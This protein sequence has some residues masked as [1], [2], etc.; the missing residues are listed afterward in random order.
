[1]AFFKKAA[2]SALA[3]SFL[4][5]TPVFAA[6]WTIDPAHSII[7]FSG[8]QTGNTFT[9][10]FGKFD[11]TVSL[12]PAHPED[13][14]ATITINIAS[15][16]T[17]DRQRDSAM[18]RSDWFNV[19]SFPTATFEAR[20]FRAKGGNAYEAVGTLTI[21][22]VS[23]PETL[24]F[25]LDINGPTAH[26]KGHLDLIRSAFGIGQGPWATGQWVALQ[27]GVTIDITASQTSG[28]P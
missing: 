22:G 8:T 10:H 11:G 2:F 17:A 18:P 9:G 1:M 4:A 15:A 12:D 19:A 24:P 7:G 21:R 16:T 23:R 3:M 20:S 26:A 14:H 27:V 5:A 28:N 25:T 6:D 13:G